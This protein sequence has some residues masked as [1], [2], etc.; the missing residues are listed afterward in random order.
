MPDG[1]DVMLRGAGSAL[2]YL[3]G[4]LLAGFVIGFTLNE[5]G[6]HNIEV[7]GF[8][9]AFL[10]C[11]GGGALWGRALAG[12]SGYG[13]GRDLM[14]AGS[15][16][17]G[18]G[19]ILAVFGLGQL[20]KLFVEQGQSD[21]PIHVLFEILFTCAMFVV[22]ALNG[23]ANG[24]ALRSGRSAAILAV[25]GGVAGGL[26]FLIPTLILDLLGRRVGGPGAAQ[27]ATM[28][29][30]ALVGIMF[31]TAAAGAVMALQLKRQA[32]A[33]LATPAA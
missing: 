26:G 15:L 12:I 21:L 25:L 10:F 19:V 30:N 6:V 8:A 13:E 31:G 9:I 23:L 16:S 7:I 2:L 11:L 29:T 17:Y 18:P 1:R 14:L 4:F 5:L 33:R 27:T 3:V 24:I 22:P 32:G 28:L 20:E